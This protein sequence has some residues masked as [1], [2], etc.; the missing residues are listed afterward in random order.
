MGFFRLVLV[1]SINLIVLP[2]IAGLE[3]EAIFNTPGFRGESTSTIEDKIISLTRLAVPGSKIR[4]ALY[5]VGRV[6]II[7][8]LADASKRG[9]DVQLVLD[10]GNKAFRNEQ[11]HAVNV[12]TQEIRCPEGENCVKFCAGP[13]KAP[14]S[15]IKIKKGYDVGGSCRGLIIN[16]NK[17]FLF[18]ELSDG[19]KNVI[20]QT[21]ANMMKHQLE[22]YN[23]LLILKNDSVLFNGLN[24]YW[25]SLKRD[26]T[27]LKKSFPTI[28]SE[29][30]RTKIYFFPRLI[31]G[32]DPIEELLKK[33]NCR[34]P[35]SRIRAAQSS[36]SRGAV[37]KQLK[38]LIYEGCYVEVIT[39]IDPQQRSPG[40]KVREAL[41]EQLIVLPYKGDTPEKQHK[42]S[43]H[44]KILIID[45]SIDNSAEK[46]PV[47]LTG[48]HNIDIFSLR[49]NDET[50]FEI[51]DRD[52]YNSYNFFLDKIV[53][54]ARSAALPIFDYTLKRPYR[55]NPITPLR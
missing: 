11:G 23:D 53:V 10:G 49:A 28:H 39:R 52:L 43:L 21:S 50:L 29:A 55:F 34:L 1:I 36:F 15:L 40:D 35:G 30:S 19:R 38:R 42:N 47:V 37:A 46:I 4:V 2:A 27:V 20:V 51:R 22:M 6:Q 3:V 9:V 31:S 16:H 33:V 44:T 8:A 48:S 24:E 7:Q 25:E 17:L 54:D 13:L 41:G 45:A 14:L 26:T 5:R 32:S 18:S 12:L